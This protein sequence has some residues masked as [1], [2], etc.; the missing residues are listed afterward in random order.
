MRNFLIILKAVLLIGAAGPAAWAG[1]RMESAWQGIAE[2]EVRLVASHVPGAGDLLG[3]QFAM[4][5]EWKVY[6][7]SPGDAGFPPVPDWQ[8]TTGAGNFQIAWPLPERFT[9][10][11]LETFGYRDGVVLPIRMEPDGGPVALRLL[12]N[13]AACAEIC[14]PVQARLELKLP[15]GPWPETHHLGSIAAALRQVPLYGAAKVESAEYVSGALK[16]DLRTAV[17]VSHPDLIVEA[18]SNLILGK[19]DCRTNDTITRCTV[20]VA[21]APPGQPLDGQDIRV[22][23]YGKNFATETVIRFPTN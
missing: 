1:E 13:Y 19:P 8:G 17:A 14:V 22:T 7:R 23:L 11:G 9:F 18:P 6:W 5:P 4:A 2:A 12:L 21:D 16:I 20:P 3:L 10:Y 15:A